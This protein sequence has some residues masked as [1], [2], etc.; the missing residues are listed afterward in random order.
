MARRAWDTLSESYRKRLKGAGVTRRQ[1]ESGK[2]LAKA[3]GHA[4]T[5]EHPERARKHPEKYREYI[6]KRQRPGGG[7][8]P[9]GPSDKDQA[10]ANF[11]NQMQD[12]LGYDDNTVRE[13]IYELMNS[14]QLSWTVIA[15]A[16]AIRARAS[17]QD[18][19]SFH[20]MFGIADRNVWWYH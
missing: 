9:E 4:R 13:S 14:E 2:S 10:Y 17:I 12:Y 6:K 11:R 20:R 19:T 16:E 3:R 7:I 18:A 5:P 15:D 8:T 1:Y